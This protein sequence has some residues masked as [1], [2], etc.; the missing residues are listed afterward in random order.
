ME[1]AKSL[2]GSRQEP[3]GVGR[4]GCRE[5]RRWNRGGLTHSVAHIYQDRGYKLD[6]EIHRELGE[7]SEEAEVLMTSET[8]QLDVREGSLLQS[9][10]AGR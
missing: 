8:P 3:S 9:S 1:A 5:S 6:S 2:E 7:K 10:R 4:A